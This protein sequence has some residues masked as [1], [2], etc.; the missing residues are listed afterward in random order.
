[1]RRKNVIGKAEIRLATEELLAWRRAR[2]GFA[3]RLR[4]EEDWYRLR[5][6]PRARRNSEGEVIAPTSAWL[7]NALMQNSSSF[8]P[9]LRLQK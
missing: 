6:T 2:E 3:A 9:V 7:F 5:V 4:E 8:T 1:M